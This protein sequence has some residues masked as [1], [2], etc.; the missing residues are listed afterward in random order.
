MS[1]KSFLTIKDYTCSKLLVQFTIC[2]WNS[3]KQLCTGLHLQHYRCD[4]RII[5]MLLWLIRRLKNILQ[6]TFNT[7]MRF[8]LIYCKVL[9]VSVMHVGSCIFLGKL[10]SSDWLLIY[11]VKSIIKSVL[12]L[13]CSY[14]SYCRK[15]M[16]INC[17]YKLQSWI[18]FGH[19]SA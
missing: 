8:V 12:C 17:S 4:I 18:D 2:K 15:C 16:Y 5:H 3:S 14:S 11:N 1:M 13:V 19:G 9:I 10:G 6:M 7:T